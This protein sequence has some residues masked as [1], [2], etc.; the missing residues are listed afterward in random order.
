MIIYKDI[1][2]GDEIISDSYNLK[3]IDGAVYEA[4]CKKITIGNDNIDIGANPSAEEADEALEEG[5]QQVID[6]VHSFRLNETSFDKKN[7]LSHLKTYMKKVK[8]AM[9]EKGASD[10]EIKDFEKGASG[11]AKKIV[12]NFKD[13]EFLIGESMDPDGMVVLLN[14]REDGVTP[15]VTVWK[16]GL[17]EMKV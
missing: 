14:Y 16:H 6:V 2:T 12:A 4:D 17:T 9:K 1:I 11:Y 5:A 13:Y 7:Y 3:E 10:D 8:E 15:F